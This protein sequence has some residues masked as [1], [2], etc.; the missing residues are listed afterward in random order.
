MWNWSGE[1][2]ERPNWEGGWRTQ[3][4]NRRGTEKTPNF[5]Q[6]KELVTLPL[7][8]SADRQAPGFN[9]NLIFLN[10]PMWPKY[11]VRSL[12]GEGYYIMLPPPQINLRWSGLFRATIGWERGG[13]LW[14]MDRRIQEKLLFI[15]QVDSIIL[16]IWHV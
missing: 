8:A 13:K 9:K 12:I 3:Q 5:S 1:G 16:A 14:A 2:G 6:D 4:P 15:L 7:Q 10:G 11:C